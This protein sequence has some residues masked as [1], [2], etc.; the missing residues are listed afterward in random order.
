[1]RSSGVNADAIPAALALDS[2]SELEATFNAHF[3]RIAGVLSRIVRD[4]GRAEELA[5]EV[6]V[7]WWR[8]PEAHGNG[9]AGW[10]YRSALR[11]GVDELR[12]EARRAKYERLVGSFRR[13]PATPHDVHAAGDERRRVRAVLATLRRRDAALLILRAD[14]FQYQELAD[15]LGLTASSVGTLLAR[16]QRAFREAYVRRYGTR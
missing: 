11:L 8:R 4:P 7:K 10:L 12:R 5:V 9:A 1:M 2:D 16:A 13:S 15:A 6:F 3:S 14:G